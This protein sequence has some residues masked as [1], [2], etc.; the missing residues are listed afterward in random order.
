MHFSSLGA[1]CKHL[2]KLDISDNAFT[3]IQPELI[4]PLKALM[5]LDVRN[6]KLGPALVDA[7]YAVPFFHALKNAETFLFSNNNITFLPRDIL[8]SNTKLRILDL[9]HIGLTSVDLGIN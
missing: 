1:L 3:Y 7:N 2:K 9:S 4:Q 5:N 8:R 6:N